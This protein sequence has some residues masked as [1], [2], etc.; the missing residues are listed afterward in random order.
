MNYKDFHAEDPD[1]QH[2]INGYNT[3]KIF[4]L[5]DHKSTTTNLTVKRLA[6]MHTDMK[7]DDHTQMTIECNKKGRWTATH[8]TIIAFIK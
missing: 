3:K 4:F 1:T 8:N 2:K 6:R 5:R 7:H